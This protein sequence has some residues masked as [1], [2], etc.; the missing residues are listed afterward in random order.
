MEVT[1]K[2]K[3]ISLNTLLK[4]A[5]LSVIAFILMQVEFSLSFIFPSFLKLDISDIPAL[6]GGLALGP[7]PGVLIL[8]FKNIING[9]LSTSTGFVGEI[10]NFSVGVFY[11]FIASYL[12]NKYKSK[13]SLILGLLIGTLVMSLVAGVLNYYFFI[14]AFSKVLGAP[15]EAFIGMANAINKN[16][17]TFKALIYWCII[18][19]NLFKGLLVSIVYMLMHNKLLPIIKKETFRRVK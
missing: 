6:L 2:N 5:M 17:N 16:V 8:L 15:I 7:I 19:F 1:T 3:K 12:Y 4:I 13:K 14:P 9:V 10:A 18:P 11:I